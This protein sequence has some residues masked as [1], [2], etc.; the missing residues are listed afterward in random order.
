MSTADRAPYVFLSYA[1]AE[2]DRALAVAD[3]LEAAGISV[4][5]D[6][7]AIAGGP[8]IGGPAEAVA[9][10]P[11]RVLAAGAT[12]GGEVLSGAVQERRSLAPAGGA[13]VGR[14][15]ELAALHAGLGATFD[16]RGRLVLLA[17]EPGIG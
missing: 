7:Q 11:E 1:S 14:E 10:P 9:L 16:G 8:V 2:R 12:A 6:R 5:I 3:A 13:F 15:K 17:G 4:W